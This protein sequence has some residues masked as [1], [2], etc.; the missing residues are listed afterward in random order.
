MNPVLGDRPL[1]AVKRRSSDRAFY[2]GMSL[3][4]VV[5]VFIGFAPTYYLKTY[6]GAPA[7]RPLVQL[8]GFL[9]TSWIVLFVVQ[10]ALI[11]NHHVR[12]HRRVGIVGAWLAGLIAI[13]GTTTAVV[14]GRRNYV[15]D[16][17]GASTFLAVPLTDMLVFAL[18]AAAAI[19]YR[20]RPVTHKRL[21]MLATIGL[22]DAAIARWRLTFIQS[23]GVAYFVVTD[24]FVVAA[25]V[26]DLV[27]RRRVD[28]ANVWG[29][30][31]LIGSQPLRLLVSHT[32]AW[33]SFA[34]LVLR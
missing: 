34:R 5:T 9:F 7:L 25:V 26:Y 6:F 3:A 19:Y 32:T 20:Q 10:T 2:I 33:L 28:P 13:V 8:H 17:F 23:N 30:V 18:L 11:A 15:A 16:S 24:L 12:L 22:L 4:S 1:V 14:S 21:M 27:T 31:L 29:G